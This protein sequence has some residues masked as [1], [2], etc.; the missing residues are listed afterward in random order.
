MHMKLTS[1]LMSIPRERSMLV[2]P[3]TTWTEGWRFSL[4][5]RGPNPSIPDGFDSDHAALFLPPMPPET[6][7]PVLCRSRLL[8]DMTSLPPPA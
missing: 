6:S 1:K 8:G 4:V 7:L 5:R 3:L 2:D